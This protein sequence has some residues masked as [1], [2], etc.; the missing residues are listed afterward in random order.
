MALKKQNIAIVLTGI[1]EEYQTLMLD[2][3]SNFVKDRNYNFTIFQCL[4]GGVYN[5]KYDVGEHNIL[6]L[7]NFD[8]FDGAIVIPN[9][10][11]Y[12]NTFHTI[13]EKIE[14]A[15][16]PIV[17]IDYDAHNTCFVGNDN[18]GE[19]K[20]I[21]EHMI[22]V[23]NCTKINFITGH[24]HNF[25]GKSRFY[26]YKDV[27]KEHNIPFDERRVFHGQFCYW[28]GE[29]AVKQFMNSELGL[30]EVIVCS[31]DQMALGA[32]DELTRCGIRVPEDIKLTGFDNFKRAEYNSVPITS[33][34]RHLDMVGETAVRTVINMINGNDVVKTQYIPANI[35]IN[36]SCGCQERKEKI[37]KNVTGVAKSSTLTEN[38]TYTE[39]RMIENINSSRN[40]DELINNLK[41]WIQ[42]LDCCE[43]YICLCSDWLASGN[44]NDI[45]HFNTNYKVYNY[46]ETML[47]V[48]SYKDGKF[49]DLV[50]FDTNKLLPQN[51]DESDSTKF[52]TFAPLHFQDRCLGYSVMATNEF[53]HFKSVIYSS[54]VVNII[55][56]LEI[57]RRE[58]QLKI[59]IDHV[60][61]LSVTDGLTGIY[62]RPG[63]LEKV[64]KIIEVHKDRNINM[65]IAYFDLDGLKSI[66]DNYGHEE[67]DVAIKS[68]ADTLKLCSKSTDIIGRIGGDEFVY[69]G[70]DYN[71]SDAERLLNKVNAKLLEYKDPFDR[72]HISCSSG[73]QIMTSSEEINLKESIELADSKMYLQKRE[74]YNKNT[75]A[76]LCI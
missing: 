9:T 16:I 10:I 24:V 38:Y 52:Y 76:N 55:N 25:E 12:K 74:K 4:N 23:H 19:M 6:N 31:N 56:A 57:V 22:N 48:I 33:V 46:S 21:V 67:G 69:F 50:E 66:N 26:A 37:N 49:L 45:N 73:Y 5:D 43:F 61:K 54:Y 27:L 41:Y 34:H 32:F 17:T 8:D 14:H 1:T 71:I 15:N 7:V 47:P 18:Y 28:D 70:L 75:I 44:V 40:F 64:Q 65:M 42:K 29:N 62:N 11:K 13:I 60:K 59:I 20:N 35:V 72:Y 68:V 63:F 39:G 53:N 36:R 30:P 51:F 58:H 2:G 3:I